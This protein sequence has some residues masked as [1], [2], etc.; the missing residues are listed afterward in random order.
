MRTILH[1]LLPLIFLAS[2]SI[3]EPGY[4]TTTPN[5]PGLSQ[6]GESRC[7]GAMG[8]HHMEFQVAV[9]PLQHVVMLGNVYKSTE[10]SY[11]FE[12]GLGG[13]IKPMPSTVIEAHALYSNANIDA[14][15][16]KSNLSFGFPSSTHFLVIK[17]KYQAMA[18]QSGITLGNGIKYEDSNSYLTFGIKADFIQYDFLR[19]DY[20]VYD[21][22]GDER[23][24]ELELQPGKKSGS[25]LTLCMT[26]RTYIGRIGFMGQLAFHEGL[27]LYNSNFDNLPG[28][29]PLW[30]TFGLEMAL[31]RNKHVAR[32]TDGALKKRPPNNLKSRASKGPGFT[33]NLNDQ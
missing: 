14:V 17:G 11:S 16:K 22:N 19:R 1:F 4:L 30:L 26:G 3:Q 9:S 15:Q 2:C 27:N 10:N 8:I 25:V 13:Y 31:G 24:E 23:R 29:S 18:L 6:K 5:I 32:P 28:Y 20:T 12:G 7:M 21:G 33:P